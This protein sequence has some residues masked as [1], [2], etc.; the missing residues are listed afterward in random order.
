MD[1]E[2]VKN[3]I[4]GLT[5]SEALSALKL[6]YSSK[7][8]IVNDLSYSINEEE[9]LFGKIL[10][11]SK[12]LTIDFLSS[13][14]PFSKFY[15]I[16]ESFMFSNYNNVYT[17]YDGS[18]CALCEVEIS[19]DGTIDEKLCLNEEELKDFN[20]DIKISREM[21][22]NYFSK[23]SSNNTEK[24]D[25]EFYNDLSTYEAKEQIITYTK[26]LLEIKKVLDLTNKLSDLSLL[27]LDFSAMPQVNLEEEND[28]F[29]FY[30]LSNIIKKEDETKK[31]NKLFYLRDESIHMIFLKKDFDLIPIYSIELDKYGQ[32]NKD[33][34]NLL[35]SFKI[36]PD[37]LRIKKNITQFFED[38]VKEFEKNK[39]DI[40]IKEGRQKTL[41]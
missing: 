12:E 23:N 6:L 18:Y 17:F 26:E 38:S 37:M 41:I 16:T 10:L 40:E 33:Y 36:T 32:I 39:L 22:K 2:Q 9:N 13:K 4:R 5:K 31:N 14:V 30:D 35:D 15:A 34:V 3:S 8:K 29:E 28:T 21:I 19:K 11:K 24:K 1:L 27:L 25:S 20:S 7:D